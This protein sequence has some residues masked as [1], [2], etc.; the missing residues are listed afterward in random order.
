MIADY[1]KK[2]TYLG[3][4]LMMAAGLVSCGRYLPP[5]P[6]ETLA[7]AA[8]TE[9][10]VTADLQAVNFNWYASDRDQAGA[11][12]KTIEGYRIYRKDLEKPND[13]VNEDIR[14]NL[15]STI[16][17]IHLKELKK[18][19][20]AALEAGTPTRKVKVDENL[21]KFTFAD[22]QVSPGRLYAYQ[23]IPV[24]QGGVEGEANK[25]VKVL[26][27]GTSSEIVQI[28]QTKLEVEEVE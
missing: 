2:I 5:V 19:K 14:Y 24:N 4:F 22:S 20:D 26:F 11:E 6:P 15:I 27:R 13:M 3:L 1:M 17:D 23:I 7:P 8:V 18:L 25:I 12:L 10:E 9:L 21:K 28:D 16:E